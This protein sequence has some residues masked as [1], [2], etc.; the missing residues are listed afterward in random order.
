VILL[1]I[2]NTVEKLKKVKKIN[3]TNAF[4]QK[5]LNSN[6]GQVAKFKDTDLSNPWGIFIEGHTAWMAL[7]GSDAIK[8]YK[9]DGRPK[10]NLI[11]VTGS[12][13]T[14]LL[15]NHNKKGFLITQGT[16]T[17]YSKII[18]VTE[19]GTIEGFNPDVTPN[20]TKSLISTG[21]VY[22]GVALSGDGKYLFVTNFSNGT[23]DKY[24]N[25]SPPNLIKSFTDSDLSPANIFTPEGQGYAPYGILRI[26]KF[27]FVTFAEVSGNRR[28][29]VS[30]LG[31][32][33][34]DV[35]DFDGNLITRFANRGHLNAPWGLLD[36]KGKLLV[37]NNGNGRIQ[38]YDLNTT[39]Y[40]GELKYDSAQDESISN[41]GLWGLAKSK[42]CDIYLTA[43]LDNENNGLFARLS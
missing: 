37:A 42:S 5:N 9:L 28:D 22:K 14:G 30:G 43:G 13:P 18:V 4:T 10:S 1:K 32:G 8:A 16:V 3:I 12:S 25:K 20:T 26:G 7:N 39:N 15:R 34:I 36:Y 27:L 19:N 31:N 29:A 23:V 21:A 33:F 11:T 38:V 2:P 17:L 6:I 35:F 41:D 40:L 24:D